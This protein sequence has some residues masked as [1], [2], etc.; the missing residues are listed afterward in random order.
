[1]VER[2]HVDFRDSVGRTALTEVE[3]P[4][5]EEELCG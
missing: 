5:A 2:N 3:L 4:G 1:M